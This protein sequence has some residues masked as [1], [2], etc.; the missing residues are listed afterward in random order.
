MHL[1]LA[2]QSPR[3]KK[4]LATLGFEFDVVP[5]DIEEIA[6]SYFAPQTAQYNAIAKAEYVA[7]LHPHSLIIGSDTVVELD[8]KI[9]GKPK[10]ISHAQS[11]LRLLAGKKHSVV[12][13]VSLRCIDNNI[14][15][16]FSVVT[17]V[18]FKHFDDSV[19]DN[20]ISLVNPLDKAG[21]YGIQIH[22]ELLVESISGPVDNVIGLPCA[23]LNEA[24]QQICGLLK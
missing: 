4:L 11:T 2:S 22:S 5:A 15:C 14:R 16:D 23:K 19:I 18:T 12:T 20:Y 10:N 9:L 21:A 17:E 8:E 24:L 1:I 3:R 6:A 13:A 7:E